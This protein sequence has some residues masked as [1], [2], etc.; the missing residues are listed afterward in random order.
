MGF[1]APHLGSSPSRAEASSVVL[2]NYLVSPGLNLPICQMVPETAL[3][4]G[5]AEDKMSK[6]TRK[7]LVN[8][9][10]YRETYDVLFKPGVV[11]WF[12]VIL[13]PLVYGFSGVVLF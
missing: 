4:Q 10:A 1:G 6:S 9:M 13:D 5:C 2:C 8:S 11:F 7:R 12:A 3:S